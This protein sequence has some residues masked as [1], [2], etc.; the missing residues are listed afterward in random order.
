MLDRELK[1]KIILIYG[2]SSKEIISQFED[3]SKGNELISHSQVINA[4]L[5]LSDGNILK[6]DKYLDMAK[7]D[8]RDVVMLSEQM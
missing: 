6:I 1:D 5:K 8:P 2:S 3:Y 7:T 4:I